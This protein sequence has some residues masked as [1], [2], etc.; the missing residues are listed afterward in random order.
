[1]AKQAVVGINEVVFTVLRTLLLDLPLVTAKRG[2]GMAEKR[3][4]TE[5]AWKGYD[6]SIRLGS[7]S[8]DRLYGNRLLGGLLVRSGHGLLRW[9]RLNNAA[10]GAFFAGLWRAT[11]LP[12][13]TE[14]N[15]VREELRALA[16]S[17]KAQ[18][19]KIE[20]LIDRP[21]RSK[22]SHSPKVARPI[23]A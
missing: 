22:A 9:Q 16:A 21:V 6:A 17:V 10:M 13:A 1:M 11:D 8:I 18:G 7:A 20:A 3:A 4:V 12:T 23:A 14:V 19:E 5:T 15:A 2:F